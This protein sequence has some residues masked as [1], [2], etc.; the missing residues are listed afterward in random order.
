MY[1][2]S[3]GI[4]LGLK[5]FSPSNVLKLTIQFALRSSNQITEISEA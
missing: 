3:I 2:V 5:V 1:S 4:S